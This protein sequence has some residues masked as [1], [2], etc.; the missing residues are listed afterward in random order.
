[1]KRTVILLLLLACASASLAQ[2]SGP[3]S[4]IL[5]PGIFHVVD[6]ISVELGDSLTLLP[7]TTF[8][9]NGGY[10]FQ[11]YGTLLA[12]GTENDSI[13]FTTDTLANPD[14]WRGLRFSGSSAL[15][16][17]LAYCRIERGY[18]T[19]Y[20]MDN[21]GGGVYCDDSSPTFANCI[22]ANNTATSAGGGLFCIYSAP[23]FTNC[24]FTHNTAQ[25]AGGGVCCDISSASTFE[26]CT[27]SGN[28][29]RWKGGGMCIWYYSS[30][31]LENCII[32]DNSADAGSGVWCGGSALFTNCEVNGNS[33]EGVNCEYTQAAFVNCVFWGN[34]GGAAFCGGG[35]PSF[36]HCSLVGNG[37]GGVYCLF[38]APVINSSIIAFSQGP[39]IFFDL[40]CSASQIE[41]C[42]FYGNSGGNFSYQDGGF[43]YGPPGIGILDSA[44]AYGEACDAYSNIVFHPYFVDYTSYDLHLTDSSWCLG[45]GDPANPPPA[46]IEGHPRP[47]PAGSHPDIGAYESEHAT[48]PEGL[49]GALS[50]TLGPGVFH[51]TCTIS[52]S[53]GDT[54]RLMPGT[55]F[56]F[57]EQ[58]AF[59]I[60]GTLFA[61]GT[62]SDSIIFTVDTL[63][64]SNRW[65]G[66]RFLGTES[67]NSRLAYCRIEHGHATGSAPH[68]NGGGLYFDHSSP[69]L[70]HCT[71]AGNMADNFG[72]GVY[73]VDSSPAFTDCAV[74]GN[75]ANDGGGFYCV[76]SSLTITR[77]NIMANVATIDGGG[78]KCITSDSV[79][80]TSC[81]ILAN[82]AGF[83]GGGVDCRSSTSPLFTRCTI[84]ANLAG[85]DGGGMFC[86]A[87]SPILSSSIVAF[88][89]GAGIHFSASPQCQ[90]VYC[91]IF[92]NSGGA[93]NGL[94]IPDSLGD[95]DTT[96]ANGDSCDIYFNIFLAPMFVDTAAGDYHLLAG[97]PCIDAGDPALPLDPDN[98]IADIGAFYYH[99]LAA[100]PI[101]VLLPKAYALH[102]NWPNP[103]NPT[104]MIRYDVPQAGKVQL[105]IFNLLGQRVATLLDQRQLAGSYTVAWDAANLPSGVYL[106]RMD[107]P[108]FVRTRKLLLVK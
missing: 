86:H 89:E 73:L 29:A 8:T 65:R 61:E 80:F 92:G 102:P 56:T 36:V 105:T 94:G 63:T 23:A 49:C 52:V 30:S 62:E 50:G 55:I 68:N 11:I 26:N 78:V 48:P 99:Q 40:D 51:I 47:N 25:N 45:A 34:T 27:F 13:V 95:M 9:F 10:P 20:W 14:K 18:A 83:S 38:S 33:G 81:I 17:R 31:T 3:L 5:G 103:F 100:E 2:L 108:Q 97:S 12:E 64:N 22:I 87:S 16:N 44:N 71:I 77:S 84:A 7:G 42:D 76:R 57:E 19:G 4:G 37:Y 75:S 15:G 60:E 74:S 21:C 69:A 46:D 39:G 43:S 59:E 66:L 32:S 24:T 54:L 70:T 6:T 72:G 106:C 79:V 88:S 85:G 28:A 67:S 53:A 104:T 90:L 96:N 107:A 101:A 82:S 98:T 58:F 1:M 41:H 93:F 35:A 91:S